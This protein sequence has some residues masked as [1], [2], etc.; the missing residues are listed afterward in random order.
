MAV[1][2][3]FSSRV[4]R[5]RQQS[6]TATSCPTGYFI[7]NGSCVTAD[8]GCKLTFGQYSMFT[9]YDS[10]TGKPT[11]DCIAGYTWNAAGKACV[12]NQIQNNQS[13]SRSITQNTKSDV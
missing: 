13:S 1:E 3:H 7:N 11:C 12:F 9:K 2:Y 5:C 8:A 4:G 10:A 6:T